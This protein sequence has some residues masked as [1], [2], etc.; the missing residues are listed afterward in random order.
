MGPG[1]RVMARLPRRVQIAL[2]APFSPMPACEPR[3]VEPLA[4]EGSRVVYDADDRRE[5]FDARR[6]NC[7]EFGGRSV[8]ALISNDALSDVGLGDP[9]M[10]FRAPTWAER[11]ELSRRRAIGDATSG[12]H[13]QRR[14]H[15][16]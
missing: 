10:A 12:R 13:L 2:V 15:R 6:P 3:A 16:S 1:C 9:S 5:L 7:A 8:V 11:R 14:T 4:S